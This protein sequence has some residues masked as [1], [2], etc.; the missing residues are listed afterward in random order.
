[1]RHNFGCAGGRFFQN[2]IKPL[3]ANDEHDQNMPGAEWQTMQLVK[4]PCMLLPVDTLCFSN[5][6][7]VK[8]VV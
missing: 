8:N 7:F 2:T 5:G 4:A 6:S 3:G 1:M